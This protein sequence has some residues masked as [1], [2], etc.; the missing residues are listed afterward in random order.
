MPVSAPALSNTSIS[1][2]STSPMH[3]ASGVAVRKSS[4][5]DGNIW[6]TSPKDLG[7]RIVAY[8][9][10]LYRE[11]LVDRVSDDLGFGRSRV[12]KW[13]EGA[14]V[15]D[16]FAIVRMIEV[17]GAPFLDAIVAAPWVDPVAD[18]AR[19]AEA[20]RAYADATASYVAAVQARA[21]AQSGEHP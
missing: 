16:G 6:V 3:A 10:A 12:A 13:I 19:L 18:A 1:F 7:E 4:E 2:S 20:E 14:S 15:P 9:R 21:V 8:L 11:K 17:Y 5:I